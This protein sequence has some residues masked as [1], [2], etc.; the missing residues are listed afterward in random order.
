MSD[1]SSGDASLWVLPVHWPSV[2]GGG[3]PGTGRRRPTRRASA[4]S[5]CSTSPPTPHRPTTI[6][7][8][9][10][11]LRSSA[12]VYAARCRPPR[13]AWPHVGHRRARWPRLSASPAWRAAAALW[14]PPARLSCP[15]LCTAQPPR[16]QH[17]HSGSDKTA[18]EGRDRADGPLLVLEPLDLPGVHHRARPADHAARERSEISLDL[19]VQSLDPITI[20]HFPHVHGQ[21]SRPEC[22][23]QGHHSQH[24]M[25][26]RRGTA[27]NHDCARDHQTA[28]HRSESEGDRVE[29]L[30]H[31][32]MI[33]RGG[34][35]VQSSGDSR[36]E[37]AERHLDRAPLLFPEQVRHDHAQR[38]LGDPVAA[39]VFRHEE[40]SH[41]DRA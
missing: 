9:V 23:G 38:P 19:T 30:V 40:Q 32:R 16:R 14:K 13:A 3:D 35:R 29:P 4:R 25:T 34:R 31:V 36:A 10:A 8:P 11:C 39:G 20:A 22:D 1:A 37:R 7:P 27:P 41:G 26:P 12:A 33:E 6:P 21:K 24:A 15:S 2:I 17:H 18:C 28:G 5:S